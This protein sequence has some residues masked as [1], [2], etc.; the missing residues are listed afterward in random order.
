MKNLSDLIANAYDSQ[1]TKKTCASCGHRSYGEYVCGSW[2]CDSCI[3]LRESDY[4]R[5]FNN[6]G[7][8]KPKLTRRGNVK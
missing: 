7:K 8:Y 1:L 4:R 6:N 5:E 3:S 2:I